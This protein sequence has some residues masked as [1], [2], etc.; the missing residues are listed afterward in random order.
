MVSKDSSTAWAAYLA[1]VVLVL[2][3]ELGA[4]I[5][6]GLRLL[7]RSDVP[8]AKGV[9]SSAALEVA[10]MRAVAHQLGIPIDGAEAAR[11]CQMAENLVVGA[12][13]GIMDQM[14]SAIGKANQLLALLCQPAEVQGFASV[15]RFARLVGNR[16]GHPAC[17]QR[18]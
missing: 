9:S 8:E 18:K 5:D 10:A 7:V 1:G 15:A 12:P 3:R 4:D 17:R 11:L 2:G 14:T 16:L 6:C 13:C